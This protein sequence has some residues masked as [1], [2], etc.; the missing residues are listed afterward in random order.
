LKKLILLA[1]IVNIFNSLAQQPFITTWEVGGTDLSIRIPANTNDYN[2]NYSIDFGDGNVLNNQTN[3]VIYTY[4]NPGIYSV[5]ISGNYPHF[6]ALETNNIGTNND[7]LRSVEQWGDIQWQSMF[8]SF[9]ECENVVINATDAPDLSQVTDMRRMFEGATNFNQNINHWDTSTITDMSAMFKNAHN[10]NQ[11]LNDWDVSNVVDMSEMFYFNIDFNQPLNNWDVSSVVEMEDMFYKTYFFNQ[12]LNN[13]DVSSVV[14]MRGMFEDAIAFNSP[15]NNWNVSNVNTMREM[16]DGAINFDQPLSNWDVS[17]VTTMK[18]MF[19]NANS[20]N[21]PIGN[22][23]ITSLTDMSRMFMYADTFNQPINSWD[24]SNVQQITAMF[25]AAPLFNQPLDNWDI[26]NVMN[27]SGMFTFASSFNQDLSSW[28]FNSINTNSFISY[29][30]MDSTNYDKLLDR[31]AQLGILDATLN[32]H[33]LKYCDEITRLQLI[34]RGWTFSD[35]GLADD[36]NF[37]Y[38]SGDVFF[39]YDNNGCDPD[40]IKLSNFMLNVNNGTTDIS[41]SVNTSGKFVIGLPQGSYAMNIENL[42]S[43]FNSVP[44]TQFFTFSGENEIIDDENFCVKFFQPYMDLTID[45]FPLDDAI[46]G[47]ESEY[48]VVVSNNGTYT[49]N[50]IQVDFTF[51]NAFQTYVS[52]TLLPSVNTT[53][54]LTFQIPSLEPFNQEIFE[55]TLQNVVPPTLNSGDVLI[56][57]A[58]VTPNNNDVDIKNNFARLDQTVVNSFDP[59]D[60]MVVQGDEIFIDDIDQYLD[61]RIRFQNL[62]TANALNVKIT[63]TIDNNLDWTTFQPISSSHDFRVEIIDSEQINY[64]FDNINLPFETADPEGSNGYITYKIKPKSTVQIGDTFENTAYIYFDFNLPII[65]NTAV[66]TVVEELSVSEFDINPIKL[67]PNPVQDKLHIDL[68]QDLQLNF[69]EL[70]DIQGKLIKKFEVENTLDFNDVLK[71]IY[72]LRLE[73]DKGTSNHK[74]VKN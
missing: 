18:E 11:S 8:A 56:L 32:A 60:K 42:N 70:F 31:F 12:N 29:T 43:N 33:E 35:N 26:S 14:N 67:Y 49:I 57:S 37:N 13:W 69:I 44:G 3:D 20:F 71:G 15:L 48:Q 61:Y 27:L 63:D 21:Q 22:W 68:P 36:C 7:K 9:F 6:Y 73:T 74:V 39:D 62:G 1:F 17:N 30:G 34:N 19:Y 72:L 16:F 54:L 5:S 50:N 28:D 10:F 59:N 66:T 47:F 38:V 23:N 40:D 64:Y 55:I 53:N 65:T 46:P 25:Y 58:E 52:S 45:I 2:Y 24:I 4:A 41:V 51:D